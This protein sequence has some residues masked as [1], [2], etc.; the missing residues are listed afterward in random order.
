MYS[1]FPCL[2]QFYH[3]SVGR[4]RVIEGIADNPNIVLTSIDAFP[5]VLKEVI[6]LGY[7]LFERECNWEEFR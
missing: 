4:D 1:S 2:D 5:K 6:A 3:R 7:E